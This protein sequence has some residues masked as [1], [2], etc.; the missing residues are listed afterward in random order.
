MGKISVPAEILSKPG[1]LTDTEF[2]LIKVHA[3]AGHDVLQTI[4][5]E[6]PVAQ[7]VL[8]HHERLDG[9]GYPNGMRG[10]DILP[11]ARVMAVADVYEA[12]T[13]HRPYRPGLPQKAALAELREGAGLRYDAAA[14]GA[15]LQALDEGFTFTAE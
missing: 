11:A 10:D 13:S 8:Q 14:V 5:F 3:Q 6:Q 4:A 15:C 7:M 12:I 2:E 9:S 1:R